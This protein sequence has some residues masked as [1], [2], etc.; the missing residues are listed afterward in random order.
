MAAETGW[1]FRRILV[2]SK[3]LRIKISRAAVDRIL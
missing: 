3:K 2:E 1:G